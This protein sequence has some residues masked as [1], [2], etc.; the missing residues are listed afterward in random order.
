[1]ILRNLAEILEVDQYIRFIP[2]GEDCNVR[3]D[4]DRKFPAKLSRTSL[5]PDIVMW[6]SSIK[7]VPLIELCLI[8]YL[9]CNPRK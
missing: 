4:L 7:T 8:S 3:V 6:S 1:M 5:H 2:E 9:N